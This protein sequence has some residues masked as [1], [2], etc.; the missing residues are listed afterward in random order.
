MADT[1]K[2]FVDGMTKVLRDE[3]MD[4]EQRDWR[5][6]NVEHRFAEV[7]NPDNHEK[8]RFDYDSRPKI[9][10]D[11]KGSLIEW[12]RGLVKRVRGNFGGVNNEQ[13]VANTRGETMTEKQAQAAREQAGFAIKEDLDSSRGKLREEGLLD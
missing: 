6:E 9:V 13:A 4:E 3:P 7:H 1:G 10:K 11:K 12:G 2:E 5:R 8:E